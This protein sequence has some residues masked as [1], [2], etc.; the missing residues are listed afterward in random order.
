[1]SFRSRHS[2]ERNGGGDKS[3]EEGEKS[4]QLQPVHF[5]SH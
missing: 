2:V 3:K 4:L 5:L 1:M